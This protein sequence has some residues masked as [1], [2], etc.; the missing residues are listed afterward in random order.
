MATL[1]VGLFEHIS[2]L[3]PFLLVWAVVFGLLSWKKVF[4]EN[5]IIH[6]IIAVAIAIMFVMSKNAVAI[7]N[8]SAPWFAIL[9]MM[10]VFILIAFKIF[11]VSDDHILS[12]ITSKDYQYITTWVILISL[13]IVL[14]A[15]SSVMGQDL[16]D[17]Q[18]EE[19]EV[20]ESSDGGGV[21]SP[22]HQ[23]SWIKTI[24]HPKVLGFL[25]VM[26]I[27]SLTLTQLTR[28]PGS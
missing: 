7:L 21:A 16:L 8:I 2:F 23:E 9:F 6:A 25:V 10:I 27:A 14:L 1:D 12:I 15:G 18:Y 24:T 20:V 26:V 4:G 19:G 13:A 5:R 3:F 28:I 11:G 17:K 22:D